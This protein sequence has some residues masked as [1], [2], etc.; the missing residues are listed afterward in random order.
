MLTY[1]NGNIWLHS[2]SCFVHRRCCCWLTGWCWILLTCKCAS[3]TAYVSS[4]NVIK[5]SKIKAS[6]TQPKKVYFIKQINMKNTSVKYGKSLGFCSHL[7]LPG[8]FLSFVFFCSPLS[9]FPFP[10]LW[11][12]K[13]L[14]WSNFQKAIYR[15]SCW[16]DKELNA[17]R[18]FAISPIK[19]WLKKSCIQLFNKKSMKNWKF[20]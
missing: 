14:V 2:F 1:L 4:V 13:A 7:L 8:V 10:C 19:A 15:K 18:K 12:T 9:V 20:R 17:V 3:S 16:F 6:S 5:W 11:Y